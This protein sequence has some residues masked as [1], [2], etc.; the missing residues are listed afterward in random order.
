MNQEFGGDVRFF[1]ATVLLGA[2]AAMVYDILRVWRR[3]HKQTLFAV[4][5]QDFLFWFVLGIFGFRLLYRYNAGT[6]RV[7]ALGGMCLG[8]CIYIGTIGRFFVTSCLKV[9]LFLTFPL[10]KGL[11]FLRKQGKLLS[12]KLPKRET[13]GRKDAHAAKERE[14]ENGT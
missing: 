12:K 6:I 8:A 4:S 10:R 3:F 9:L 1:L 7:F 2:A 13:H 14:E 11:N 5:L